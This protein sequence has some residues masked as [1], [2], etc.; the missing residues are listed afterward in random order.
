MN[1]E[2]LLFLKIQIASLLLALMYSSCEKP[3]VEGIL[4]NEA[5]KEDLLGGWR[6]EYVDFVFNAKPLAT[7]IITSFNLHQK[8]RDKL[9]DMI[10][11]KS[12]YF[13]N[14]TMYFIEVYYDGVQ[15]VRSQSYYE[16][17]SRPAR[18]VPENKHLLADAYADSLYVDI[19]T[20]STA[21]IYMI[22][23]QVIRLAYEDEGIEDKYVDMMDKYIEKARVEIYL[24]RN[25]LRIYDDLDHLYGG[26]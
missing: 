6:A 1:L 16:V 18:I 19:Q 23:P 3:F 24:K 12:I 4:D 14:D 17:L 7:N 10:K 9:S 13:M 25:H 11:G 20:D 2:K 5:K 8:L 22:K 26:K 15:R 21:M